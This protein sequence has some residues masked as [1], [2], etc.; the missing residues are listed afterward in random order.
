MRLRDSALT[1]ELLMEIPKAELHIYIEGSLEPEMMF[2]MAARN[3]LRLRHGSVRQLR[4]AYD[5]ADLQSFLDL[6]SSGD[7]R[8]TY[9]PPILNPGAAT[10]SHVLYRL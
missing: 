6:Y 1:D 5:F 7:H 10:G 8:S 3:E 4:E 9:R 2:E